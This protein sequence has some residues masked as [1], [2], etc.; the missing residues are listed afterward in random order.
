[1]PY[2]IDTDWAVDYLKGVGGKV[3]FLQS[4]EEL[5]ISSISVGELVEGIIDSKDEEKRREGLE[6]LLTKITVVPFTGK[7]ARIFGRMRSKL[8]N[9]GKLPGDIDIMIGATA[10]F[11]DLELLTENTKH[12]KDM[13]GVKLHKNNKS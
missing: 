11:M 7:I 3:S 6:N 4:A 12:Y 13:D 5:Y 1:M 10:Q 9:K 2:L 8:R